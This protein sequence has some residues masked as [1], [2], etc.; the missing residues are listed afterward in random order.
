MEKAKINYLVDVVMLLAFL[1]TAVSGLVM[2]FFL[3]EG[4]RQ[5][6]YQTF[7][8]VQKHSWIELHNFFGI[9]FLIST[10]VHFLLHW[11]WVTC[12][13]KNFLRGDKCEKK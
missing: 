9:A 13:T 3:P 7:F 5:G 1:I 11:D 10:I 8:S 12:M 2:F 6:G 4:I